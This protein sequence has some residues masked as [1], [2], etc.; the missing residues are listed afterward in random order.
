MNRGEYKDGKLVTGGKEEVVPVAGVK[1]TTIT[2]SL[3][4][5]ILLTCFRLKTYFIMFLLEEK[6]SKNHKRSF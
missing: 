2:V 4:K 5:L 6:P 3:L 1:G